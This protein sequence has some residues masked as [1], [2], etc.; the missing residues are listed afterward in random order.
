GLT[1]DDEGNPFLGTRGIRLSLLKPDVFRV[2]LR[3]LC[4][5][6]THGNLK[7]MLPMVATPRDLAQARTHLEVSAAGLAAQRIPYSVPQL[8]FMVEVPAAAISIDRF[9]ADFYSIGS[10]DLTQYVMAAARDIASLADYADAADPAVLSLI[11][12]VVE[13]GRRTGCEVSLCGDA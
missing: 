1:I 9:D 8:G 12:R 5:A 7:I 10:N 11:A 4:R 3:A 13:H 2:Q 6:A